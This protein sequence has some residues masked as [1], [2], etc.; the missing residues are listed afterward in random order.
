MSSSD[1]TPARG[2]RALLRLLRPRHWAKNAVIFAAPIFAEAWD[3]VDPWLSGVTAFVAFCLLASGIYALNDLLD[4]EFDRQHPSK[5]HRP[6]ASGSISSTTA[7]LLSILCLAGGL[8]IAATLNLSTLILAGS[9]AG[10]MILY[11]LWLKHVLLLDV[12]L[13]A[14]GFTLRAMAGAAAIPVELSPW[15]VI[16]AFLIALTLALV[17]RRQELARL[18][19]AAPVS[20]R[21]SLRDA[22]PVATWDQWITAMA[23]ITVL[24]YVLYTVDPRTVAHVG[25]NH[26]LYTTPFVIY[27]LFRYLGQI[28]TRAAGEDPVDALLTDR[29]MIATLAGWLAIV[30]LVLVGGA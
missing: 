29:G 24:A 12:L 15:L 1:P 13:I 7:V 22:P 23:G 25:S 8:A 17:K 2:G 6:I 5:R 28:Q 4:V 27:A 30:L 14:A 26:L 11:S 21:R 16:C 20:T 19:D 9:Y 18:G 3:A 10:M